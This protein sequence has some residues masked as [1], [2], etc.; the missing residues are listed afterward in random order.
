MLS[1][2]H[3]KRDMNTSKQP[4]KEILL[5]KQCSVGK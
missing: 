5:L 2:V 4:K 3:F 1:V